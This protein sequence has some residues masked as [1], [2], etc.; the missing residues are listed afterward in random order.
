[1]D[2]A[3]AE[4]DNYNSTGSGSTKTPTPLWSLPWIEIVGDSDDLPIVLWP[5]HI[6]EMFVFKHY[7]VV[8]ASIDLYQIKADNICIIVQQISTV[9]KTPNKKI[10]KG[11]KSILCMLASG[12][13]GSDGD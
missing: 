12:T 2:E 6:P 8:L 5:P 9:L 11:H 13:K 1:M 10:I 7:C 3:G 4:M